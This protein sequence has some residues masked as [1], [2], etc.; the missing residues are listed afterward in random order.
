MS[1]IKPDHDLGKVDRWQRSFEPVCHSAWN[2]SRLLELGK[3][4]LD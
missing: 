4:V 1:S 2:T 3:K